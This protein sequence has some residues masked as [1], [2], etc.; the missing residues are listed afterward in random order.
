MR[1]PLCRYVQRGNRWLVLGPAER[2]YPGATVLVTTAAGDR[3]LEQIVEVVHT[4]TSPE[5]RA[6]AYGLPARLR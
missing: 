4:M 2:I 3:R 5:G 6:L 1:P